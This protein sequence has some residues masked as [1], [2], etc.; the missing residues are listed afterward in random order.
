MKRLARRFRI[1]TVCLACLGLLMPVPGAGVAQ[2]ANPSADRAVG[3]VHDVRLGA[4]GSFRGRLVDPSGKPLSGQTVVLR[5]ADKVLAQSQSGERG[6]FS[7]DRVRGGVYQVT[8][9]ASA[10]ACR[11]WPQRAAPPSASSQ[12]AIVTHPDIIRGQEPISSILSDPLF[13]GLIIAAAI[14]IP[15]AIHSSQDDAS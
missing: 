11:V 12:L 9:G 14:A 5:Q 13:V 2:S 8:I 6:E 7:F 10:V 3:V 4:D 15:V 1:V